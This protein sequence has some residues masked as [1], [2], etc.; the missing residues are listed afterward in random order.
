MC[1]PSKNIFCKREFVVVVV[2]VALVNI[3]EVISSNIAYINKNP[4]PY[5]LLRPD[6]RGLK[7]KL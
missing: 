6:C 7:L 5:R 3:F 2:V 1:V 4:G